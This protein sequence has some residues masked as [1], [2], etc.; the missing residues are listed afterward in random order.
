MRIEALETDY[1]MIG[2]RAFMS[3]TSQPHL[4]RCDA[5]DPVKGE[6]PLVC[7]NNTAILRVDLH[8]FL[9]PIQALAVQD[10]SHSDT[11]EN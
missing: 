10:R 7:Q 4:T 6:H 11:Q 5:E 9:Q 8:A 2:W 1:D 3:S